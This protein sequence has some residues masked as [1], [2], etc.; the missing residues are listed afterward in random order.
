EVLRRD[1]A[2]VVGNRD[3]DRALGRMGGDLNP[4][5]MRRGLARVGEQGEEERLESVL[6]ARALWNLVRHVDVQL[7]RTAAH[8]VLQD[9]RRRFQ[10][11]ANLSVAARSG[12]GSGGREGRSW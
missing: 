2:A 5:A 3:L 10:G 6:A 1:A 8:A 9:R 11:A 7:D 4:P 12:G